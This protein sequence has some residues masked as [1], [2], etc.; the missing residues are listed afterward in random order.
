[1]LPALST[2]PKSVS[3][4]VTGVLSVICVTVLGVNL[5]LKELL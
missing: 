2:I 4:G 3:D 1:M 5:N